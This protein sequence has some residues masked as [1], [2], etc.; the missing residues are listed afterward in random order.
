MTQRQFVAL[1]LSGIV[2]GALLH[3]HLSPWVAW[4]T[5]MV[6]GGLLLATFLFV[7]RK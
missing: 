3:G 2:L 1:L 5:V 4:L 7:N 6:W